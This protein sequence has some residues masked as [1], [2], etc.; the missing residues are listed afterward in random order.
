MTASDDRTVSYRPSSY[1]WRKRIRGE[2]DLETLRIVALELVT[3]LEVHKA[4][5]R[6]KGFWPPK[7]TVTN[8]EAEAKRLS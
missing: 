8:E 7:T 4:F 5:I 1:Y 6:E 3:E 2:R